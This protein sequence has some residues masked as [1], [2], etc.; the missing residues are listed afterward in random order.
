M[1]KIMPYQRLKNQFE[2][3]V[4]E[5]RHRET[6]GMFNYP[7]ENINDSTSRWALKDL[8]ERVAAAEQ[9]GFEVKLIATKSALEVKYVK[10]I[11]TPFLY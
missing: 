2:D 6:I 10:K 11:E 7:L 4:R 5:C 9:L 1:K 3:F 8:Y